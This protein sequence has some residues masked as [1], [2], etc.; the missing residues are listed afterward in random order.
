MGILSFSYFTQKKSFVLFHCKVCQKFLL[1]LLISTFSPGLMLPSLK[2]ISDF[3]IHAFHARARRKLFPWRTQ[4]IFVRAC[5]RERSSRGNKESICSLQTTCE[6]NVLNLTTKVVQKVQKM[7]KFTYVLKIKE[8]LL[9][10]Y[11]NKTCNVNG[12]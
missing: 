1:A 8:R 3:Q 4:A 2:N 9:N 10:Y 12:M 6:S 11:V 5:E 7:P